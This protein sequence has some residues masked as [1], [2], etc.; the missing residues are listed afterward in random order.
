M[1]S[2]SSTELL[3]LGIEIA[4]VYKAK[5]IF[6]KNSRVSCDEDD[7]LRWVSSCLASSIPS[8]SG[9]DGD[10]GIVREAEAWVHVCLPR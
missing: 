2:V 8:L 6:A 5:I 3:K 9:N 4:F 7:I 1:S 10:G